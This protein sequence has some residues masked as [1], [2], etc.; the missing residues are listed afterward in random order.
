MCRRY[1]RHLEFEFTV[2]DREVLD[3]LNPLLVDQ[4]MRREPAKCTRAQVSQPLRCWHVS[5]GLMILSTT[6]RSLPREFNLRNKLAH[7]LP[8]R[9]TLTMLVANVVEHSLSM[10]AVLS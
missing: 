3:R 8:H 4:L 2:D 7:G 1:A 6:M 9:G 10:I 5:F